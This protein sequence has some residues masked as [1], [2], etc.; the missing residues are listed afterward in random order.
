M[1][2]L[3]DEGL[4]GGY[5]AIPPD[6]AAEVVSTNDLAYGLDRKISGYLKAGVRLVWVINPD[7]RTVRVYRANGSI[8]ALCERDMLTGEQ[9]VPGFRCSV[10]DLFLPQSG[11]VPRRGVR[12]QNLD[13]PRACRNVAVRGDED[14]DRAARLCG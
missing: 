11:R 4:L 1:D 8:S 7:L 14:R 13:G 12:R 3:S 2:R 10:R 6:L 5:I 9:V